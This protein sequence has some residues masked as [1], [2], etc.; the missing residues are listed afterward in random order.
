[1]VTHHTILHCT[2]HHHPTLHTHTHTHHPTPHTHLAEHHSRLLHTGDKA[3]PQSA[4]SAEGEET[5]IY[6]EIHSN[7]QE[8]CLY[9][10]PSS[11]L[12]MEGEVRG[13]EGVGVRERGDVKK[14]SEEEGRRDGIRE[15]E[16]RIEGKGL[17]ER[18]GGRG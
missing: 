16:G 14:S 9:S 11:L 18:G 1:M 13:S 15:G 3:E 12:G 17:K 8:C 4:V 5:V 2:T 6:Y 7:T 10:D